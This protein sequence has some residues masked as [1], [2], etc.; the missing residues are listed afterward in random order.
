MIALVRG[1]RFTTRQSQ[2]G[3]RK[4]L[5]VVTGRCAPPYRLV[6]TFQ[7]IR[8]QWWMADGVSLGIPYRSPETD[9]EGGTRSWK[10]PFLT[11]PTLS[12]RDVALSYD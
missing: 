6:G 5:M 10:P 9:I 1:G 7:D 12:T 4:Q 11:F 2:V 3:R 8:P